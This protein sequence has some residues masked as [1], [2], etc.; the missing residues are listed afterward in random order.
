M[1]LRDLRR[2]HL[3]RRA[4]HPPESTAASTRCDGAGMLRDRM[5][6]PATGEGRAILREMLDGVG[7]IVIGRKGI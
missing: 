5:L 2:F 4:R 6:G 3:A 1:A 7:A